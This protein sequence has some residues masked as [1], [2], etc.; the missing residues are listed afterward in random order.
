M[1]KKV[2]VISE[3]P[4]PHNNNLVVELLKQNNFRFKFYYTKRISNM[5]SF[6]NDVFLDHSSIIY[7]DSAW[8]KIKF[9]IES[10]INIKS[11]FI[12]IGWPS[13][14]VKL[15]I[16]LFYIMK[17]QFFFWTDNPKEFSI[18]KACYPFPIRIIRNIF[19]YIL[20][21]RTRKIFVVGEHT[22]PNFT[23]HGFPSDK[24][25]NLPIFVNLNILEYKDENIRKRSRQLYQV[26]ENDFFILSGSRL[27][28]E[29]GYDILLSSIKIIVDR[30]Y[31]GFKLLLIGKGEQKEK[32]VS[33]VSLNNLQEFVLFK[34][35]LPINEFY[36]V[37][38]SSD[39]FIHPARFDAFGGGTL[40]AM[41]LGIPVVGSEGAGSVIERVVEGYNGFRYNQEDYKTLSDILMKCFIN[42]E[43]LNS[44]GINARKTAEKWPPEKGVEIIINSI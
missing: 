21:V 24:L 37:I 34:D 35:W 1:S 27:T 23:K 31:T 40:I 36:E 33:Y 12:F 6:S 2:Y 28:F 7:L 3:I 17:K 43:L 18:Y 8:S 39:L 9:F 15:L 14:I 38:A 16:L 19:Y 30:G 22:K 41:S 44:L 20:K 29:K 4:T 26:K 11:N 32:L 5:Y 42:R 25:V 10:I 13:S